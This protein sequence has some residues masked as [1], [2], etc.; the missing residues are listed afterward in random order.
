LSLPTSIFLRNRD[1]QALGPLPLQA[2]EVLYDSRIV[3]ETTPVSADGASFVPLG[4]AG[5][6]FVR[7]QQVKEMAVNGQDPW[8]QVAA[9]ATPAR[10]SV[11]LP[12]GASV[13]RVMFDCARTNASGRLTVTEAEGQISLAYSDGKIST[14]EATISKLAI[15]PFLVERGVCDATALAAATQRAPSVGGDI[16][17]AL[18]AGGTVQPHIY[19]E[20]LTEWARHVIGAAAAS[21]GHSEFVEED[22]PSAAVPLGL[23]RYR[24]LLEALRAGF[25]KNALEARLDDKMRRLL[26]PAGV[27][28]VSVEQLRLDPR[29]LRAFRSIN[30]TRN[31]SE[32]LGSAQGRGEAGPRV[33]YLMTELGFVVFGDDPQIP[34]ERAEARQLE[35]LLEQWEGVSYYDILGTAKGAKD[36]DVRAQYMDLA[37]QY[38]PDK[39]RVN[40]APELRDVRARIFARVQQAFETLETE[41]GR[42]EYDGLLDAGVTRKEDEQALVAQIL[43]AENLFKKAEALARARNYEGAIE[44]IKQAMELKGDDEEFEIHLIYYEFL[45]RKANREFAADDAIRRIVVVM[46]RSPKLAAGHLFLGRLFKVVNKPDKAVKAFQKVLEVDPRNTEA[47]SE[48]RLA[49]MRKD[50]KRK[51]F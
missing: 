42:S 13:I 18:I 36:S 3:D 4:Q 25:T 15:G 51:L 22:V 5:P 16:G 29:E 12:E 2:L 41:E 50:K 21:V 11:T 7:V 49:N 30:G 33:A 17:A 35:D 45:T 1:G 27:E 47:A 46:K 26:I 23:D 34:K 48:L 44:A 28:G 37:K 24:I 40:A 39:V 14:V 8:A 10:P 43:E 32:L 9:P 19:V 38:H 20:K 6:L 31:V